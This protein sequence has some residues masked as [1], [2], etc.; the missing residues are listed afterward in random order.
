MGKPGPYNTF[1]ID[2]IKAELRV[3]LL[4]FILTLAN[5]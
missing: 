4:L 2:V 3:Y 1:L 5:R